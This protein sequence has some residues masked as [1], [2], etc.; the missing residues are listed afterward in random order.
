MAVPEVDLPERVVPLA[1]HPGQHSYRFSLH[2]FNVVP[3]GRRSGKTLRAKRKLLYHALSAAADWPDPRF[4]AAAP[5]RDQAKTIFWA[6]LKFM[7]PREFMTTPPRESDLSIHL[8]N[9]AEIRV[10]GLD[11]PERFEGPPWDGGVLDEYANCRREA[12]V[13][14][15]RPALA[16]RN[17]WADFIGVPEGRNHYYDLY[18]D[19]TAQQARHG[20]LSDWGAFT[21]RSEEVLPLYGRESEIEAARRD[22]DPLTYEQEFGASFITFQGQAYQGFNEVLHCQRLSWDKQEPLILCFDFNV[23]PGVAV[24]CQ[25][26]PL[27]HG[28]NGTAVIGQVVIPQNS[29]T[30]KV[31]KQLT[32]AYA[33]HEG[34]FHVHGDSTGGGRHSAAT[35]GS[36]WELVRRDLNAAFGSERVVYRYPMSNPSERARLNA[37]NSRLRSQAGVVRLMVDPGKAPDVVKDL[38]G[39][40]LKDDGSGELDK[41]PKATGNGR[42]THLSDALGYYIAESHPVRDTKAVGAMPLAF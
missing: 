23:D 15:I 31:V 14:H 22:M 9:G 40:Q 18:R 25:E 37:M 34:F 28:V 7:I 41:S 10:V 42:L 24:I 3:A 13:Q 1:Y 8:V 38:E 29:T 30:P 6:D 4:F 39:V 32:T 2:R 36:D 5:T 33:D 21:W 19:A 12:W 16:D 26:Q 27:P 11:R 20:L 17:G 35:E